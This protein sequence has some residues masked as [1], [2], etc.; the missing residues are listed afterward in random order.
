MASSKKPASVE[1]LEAALA[2]TRA[3]LGE[4][5][6]ELV[7]CRQRTD[8]VLNAVAFLALSSADETCA[9]FLQMMLSL[10]GKKSKKPEFFR[11]FQRIAKLVQKVD[12]LGEGCAHDDVPPNSE[13]NVK[14]VCNSA[15]IAPISAVFSGRARLGCAAIKPRS[16]S[17]SASRIFWIVGAFMPTPA[18]V[19]IGSC[20]LLR[21][22]QLRKSR[23]RMQPLVSS[24]TFWTTA[25][26]V[27]RVPGW[28]KYAQRLT[29][30]SAKSLFNL[31]RTGLA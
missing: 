3:Q 6:K 28:K 15:A 30:Y 4:V 29:Q 9:T 27:E 2:S 10:D 18:L 1:E 31:S 23:H 5:Q 20:C 16:I 11:Q 12:K 24:Q 21:R 8:A 19:W 14:I 22:M 13:R 7:M 25:F 26:S 17:A